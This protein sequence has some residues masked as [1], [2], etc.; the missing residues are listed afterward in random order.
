[1]PV[2]VTYCPLCN[3]GIAFQRP[4]IDG[5]L[6]DFGTSGKLHNSNLLMYDRQTETLWAQAT[7][8]AVVG[9]LTGLQLEFVAAQIL[10]FADWSA[11]NPDGLVLSTDTGTTRSYGQNPYVGYDSG[12]DPF[13]FSGE[14]DERLPALERVLGYRGD[15]QIVAFPYSALRELAEGGWA[16]VNAVVGEIELAVFWKR[17]T[18][19]A[20]DAAAIAGSRDVGATGAFLR[21]IH[22]RRLTFEATED[23]IV[24][25]ETGT[26][27]TIA[28]RGV[29]GRLAGERLTA[30]VAIESFWFDWAAFH[31]E[32]EVF[33]QG[34]TT[35]R[36]G[37]Y[38]WG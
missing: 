17:G 35:D 36:R 20:L 10:S 13:L 34:G 32:T 15:G 26:A 23:G 24:D 19:S 4:T 28:G 18:T 21:E 2:A 8:Q 3:T 7:G 22:G 5:D 9:P 27:W 37:N 1:M 30:A 12:D 6:L 38:G 11:A 29:D 33:G 16:A 25:R 14:A 31:P